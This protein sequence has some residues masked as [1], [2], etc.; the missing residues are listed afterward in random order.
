MIFGWDVNKSNLKA[1]RA[2][3]TEDIDLIYQCWVKIKVQKLSQCPEEAILF[4]NKFSYNSTIYALYL[5][6]ILF[7]WQEEAFPNDSANLLMDFDSI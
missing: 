1:E 6:D 5:V 4:E 7:M 3:P 2:N